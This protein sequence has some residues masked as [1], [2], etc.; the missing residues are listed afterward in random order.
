MKNVILSTTVVS[1]LLTASCQ[2]IKEEKNDP[3]VI[4]QKAIEIHDEIMPEISNFDRQGILIDSL[5]A[6]INSVK[7][8]HQELDT[9]STRLELTKLKD[10]LESAT[11]KMML[12]M[13]EYNPDSTD[14]SYQHAE[15]ESIS[16][17]KEEFETVNKS[18]EKTLA[19]FKK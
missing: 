3:K 17:L 9:A 12:W 14:V 10:D 19:P 8:N 16:N 11:D 15:V 2:N 7:T 4:S 6:D 18:A 13:K 5:L 1:L